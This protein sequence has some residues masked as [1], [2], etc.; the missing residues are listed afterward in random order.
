MM[1][2]SHHISVLGLMVFIPRLQYLADVYTYI[3]PLLYIKLLC[4]VLFLWPH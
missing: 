3:Q 1:M 4:L 2:V